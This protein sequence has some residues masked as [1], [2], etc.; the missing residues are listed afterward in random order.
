MERKLKFY[1]GDSCDLVNAL[2]S[3]SKALEEFGVKMELL[4]G[5]TGYEEIKITK[6]EE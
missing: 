1:Y 6:K 4:E 3:L 5:G 2:E